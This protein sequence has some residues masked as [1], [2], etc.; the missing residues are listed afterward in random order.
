MRGRDAEIRWG[1]YTAATLASFEIAASPTGGSITGTVRSAD[2]FK[3]AQQPLTF[4]VRRQTGQVWEWPV[5]S[6]HIAGTALSG[7]IRLQE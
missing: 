1:Y 4:V 3:V 7:R 2:A 6:L 5:E